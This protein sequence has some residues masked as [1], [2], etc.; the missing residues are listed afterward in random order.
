MKNVTFYFMFLLA[1]IVI[2]PTQ[3]SAKSIEPTS[4][5]ASPKEMPAEVRIMLD[6]LEEIKAMDKSKLKS[7]EKKALRKEVKAIKA[8]LRSS[9]NGVYLSVGAVI[10]IILILILIL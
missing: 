7:T 9:G 1:S 6:R 10:I 8:S 3:L 2:V 4:I 5:P